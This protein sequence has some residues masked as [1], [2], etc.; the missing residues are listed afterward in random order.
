MQLRRRHVA[1]LARVRNHLP[2]LDRIAALDHQFARMSIGRDEAIR[3]ADQHQ[4]AVTFEF[5]AGISNDAVIGGLDRG[6][7]RHRQID[8]VVLRAVWLAAEAGN[9][10]AAS[11][12]SGTTAW[13]AAPQS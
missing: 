6:A 10:P 2:A 1:G 7:L 8:T 12:A 11:R 9:D 4:I 13:P 3:V 5:V